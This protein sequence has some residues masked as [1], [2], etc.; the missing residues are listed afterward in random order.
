M[1]LTA[2]AALLLLLDG[3]GALAQSASTPVGAIQPP[4][5][6]A[7]AAPTVTA[8]DLTFGNRVI[9]TFRA[10]LGTRS[11]ADRARAATT[12]IGAQTSAGVTGPVE[13]HPLQGAIIVTLGSENAFVLLPQDADD[14]AGETLASISEHAVSQLR[15][16]V[17][18]V[19]ELHKP[20]AMIRAALLASLGTLV[21]AI[22]FWLVYLGHRRTSARLMARVE[23]QLA[24]YQ[25]GSQTQPRI[26]PVFRVLRGIIRAL[27]LVLASLIGYTWL[28]FV[29][30]RFPYT[31]PW[32][33]GLRGFLVSRLELLGLGTV[34]ALPGLFTVAVI[35]LVTRFVIYCLKV[36]FDAV[37]RGQVQLPFVDAELARPTGHI[38]AT[39]AWIF[40]IVVAYPYIPGS[41]TD[42]FKGVSVFVGL[43]VSLGSS[44]LVNQLMSGFVIT[45]SR[46]V[47]VGEFA[48]IADI[49]GTVTSVGVLATTVRTP[50]GEEMNIPN[51][52]V[53]SHVVTNYSR[54]GD[55]RAVWVRTSVTIGYDTPWRQVHAMLLEAA[56][57]TAGLA[58]NPAPE[59]RQTAL[60]DYYVEYTLLAA[61]LEARNRGPVFAELHARIQDAFNEHGVQIMSPHYIAD[62][63]APKIVPKDKWFVPP[64]GRD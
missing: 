58:D 47:R 10:D 61:P 15:V 5:V 25:L 11:P 22:L 62:P 54:P 43:I 39:L 32:G 2:V 20:A 30:N 51:A 45:Y 17:A 41:S 57:K 4:A 60:Q 37:E 28:T 13:A 29:L 44:G 24:R 55:R 36:L 63:G 40:C 53:V 16:A 12:L 35:V 42:A 7:A 14:L 31:R 48:R 6:A 46:S 23:N 26:T 64:A 34:H 8:A 27:T 3:S 9:T 33:E 1:R 19:E 21:A 18:E 38:V 49:E 50:D 56:A 52:V 59:V